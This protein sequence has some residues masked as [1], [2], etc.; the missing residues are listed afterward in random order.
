MAAACS[1][2]NGTGPVVTTSIPQ[3]TSTTVAGSIVPCLSGDLPFANEGVIAAI[4]DATG[5]AAVLGGVRWEADEGCERVVLD[6]L[7]T[8][9]SPASTLGPA[10]AFAFPESGV[11]RI[12][13]PPEIETSAV[14]DTVLGGTLV[15]R[16]YV[17]RD[18]SNALFVDLHVP[19]GTAVAARAFEVASPIRLVVDLRPGAA[20]PPIAHPSRGADTVVLGPAA[21][22]ALYPLRI[23]GYARGD[24]RAVRIR[25]LVAGE[26]AEERSVATSG[27]RDVWKAFDVRL[28]DGPSGPVD[29][30][31]GP[32]DAFEEPVGG[33]VIPLEL[34]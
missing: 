27:F 7:G 5:D 3:A 13:L 34:P 30:Y 1:P 32:V 9:G 18:A 17:V 15:E 24:Q 4:G 26:I 14:A 10:G 11:I 23:A 20:E 21:G 16:A 8:A 12:T 33:V 2:G 29:L 22:G 6:F 28:P 19:E 25:L 31:V